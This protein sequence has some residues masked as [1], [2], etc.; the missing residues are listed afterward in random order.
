MSITSYYYKRSIVASGLIL[1]SILG[2]VFI[3]DT[4]LMPPQ[5]LKKWITGTIIF[6][7]TGIL[8]YP[9]TKSIIYTIMLPIPLIM[10]TGKKPFFIYTP[11]FTVLTLYFAAAFSPLLIGFL[12]GKKIEEKILGGVKHIVKPEFHSIMLCLGLSLISAGLLGST[13]KFFIN[14]IYGEQYVWLSITMVSGLIA[15]F[16]PNMEIKIIYSLLSPFS[17]A[18]IAGVLLANGE[19]NVHLR[20]EEVKNKSHDRGVQGNIDFKYCCKNCFQVIR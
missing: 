4:S 2:L 8:A 7:L 13:W 18:V 11:Q 12:N 3:L 19:E 15:S 20:R 10:I 16:S 6:L 14:T 9:A 5:S 1:L 17:P